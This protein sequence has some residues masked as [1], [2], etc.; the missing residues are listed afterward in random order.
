M[1]APSAELWCD[2]TLSRPTIVLRGKNAR[3][4]ENRELIFLKVHL[5]AVTFHSSVFAWMETSRAASELDINRRRIPDNCDGKTNKQG[6]F[7]N[8]RRRLAVTNEWTR[9]DVS[10]KARGGRQLLS[11]RGSFH[12]SRGRIRNEKRMWDY[13]GEMNGDF[14]WGK[15][16]WPRWWIGGGLL[17]SYSVAI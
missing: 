3:S 12:L 9:Q 16:S 8:E 2:N 10:E 11:R 13:W 6:F 7:L 15:G 17:S 1:C 5:P 4:L 14:S